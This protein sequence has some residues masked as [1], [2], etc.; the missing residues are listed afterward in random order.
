MRY[1]AALITD[2]TGKILAKAQRKC[3]GNA[4]AFW[5]MR[6]KSPYTFYHTCRK[7]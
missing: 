3:T 5:N 1:Q 7:S 4:V 6:H 2:W